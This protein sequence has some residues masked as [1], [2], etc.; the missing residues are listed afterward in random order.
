MS[1]TGA[2][3]SAIVYLTSGEV[4]WIVRIDAD[5]LFVERDAAA[6]IDV[7]KPWDDV[8]GEQLLLGQKPGILERFEIRQLAQ[9]VEPKLREKVLGRHVGV[10]RPPAAGCAAPKQ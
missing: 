6:I 4:A 8:T 7:C 9:C 5:H 10:G 3:R 2:V 1:A